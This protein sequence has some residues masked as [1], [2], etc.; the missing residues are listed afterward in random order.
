M[1]DKVSFGCLL[2]PTRCLRIT[3]LSVSSRTLSLLPAFV[4][5]FFVFLCCYFGPSSTMLVRGEPL[6]MSG[7]Q[8]RVKLVNS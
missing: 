4:S 8:H 2:R 3:F 5:L 7:C 6:F 1:V